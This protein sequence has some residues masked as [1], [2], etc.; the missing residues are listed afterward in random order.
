MKP[1][2]KAERDGQQTGPAQLACWKTTD[3]GPDPVVQVINGDEQHVV[4]RARS[5]G[6]VQRDASHAKPGEQDG[7]L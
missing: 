7:S 5:L 3:E 1:D 4:G 2:S 6:S